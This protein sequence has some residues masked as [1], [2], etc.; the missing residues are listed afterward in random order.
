MAFLRQLK[1][2]DFIVRSDIDAPAGSNADSAVGVRARHRLV[3]IA[4]GINNIH[5]YRRRNH[6]IAGRPNPSDRRTDYPDD[7]V[8]NPVRGADER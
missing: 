7:H 2:I 5:Q 4:T 8:I 6:V 3:R 1:S